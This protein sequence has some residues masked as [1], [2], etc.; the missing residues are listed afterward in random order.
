[1]KESDRQSESSQRTGEFMH[2]LVLNQRKIQAFILSTTPNK[3]DAEDIL[4]DVLTEMWNKFDQF[5]PGTN[6]AAWGCTIA[7]YKVIEFR[8]KNRNSRLQ[9]NDDLVRILEYESQNHNQSGSVYAEALECCLQKLAPKEIGLLKHRYE[10]DMT[11]K[12]IAHQVGISFQGVH[13][14]ISIIHVKLLRCIG[15]NLH[16]KEIV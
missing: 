8:R 12:E 6:F 2:L 1:M 7:K 13:K 11:L 15:Y 3:T 9:F 10:N 14:A 4:Q 16:E 5:K